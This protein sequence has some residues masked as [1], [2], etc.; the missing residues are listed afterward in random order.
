MLSVRRNP[1]APG[2][3]RT[4]NVQKIGLLA[5]GTLVGITVLA[6]GDLV[7][8][9]SGIC[10]PSYTYG[11]SDVGAIDPV[12]TGVPYT[13][14]TPHWRFA[15]SDTGS[16]RVNE[17]GFRTDRSIAEIKSA[18]MSLPIAVTGDS[19]T[20]LPYG[21]GYDHPFVLERELRQA[22]IRGAEVFGLGR[23]TYS[24]LQAYLFVKKVSADLNPRVI[25]LNLYSGN[26][27]FDLMR[28]D[29]RP[30]FEPKGDGTY[31]IHPPVWYR[32]SDPTLRGSWTEQSRLLYLVRSFGR[33]TGIADAIH[34]FS[35]LVDLAHANGYGFSHALAYLFALNASKG[36]NLV[37]P[38]AYPSQILN[39]YLFF[40]YFPRTKA[41]SLRR[42]EYLLGMIRRQNPGVSL[43]LSPIPSAAL[44]GSLDSDSSFQGKLREMGISSEDVIEQESALLDSSRAIAKRQEWRF[45]DNVSALQK[46]EP[47]SALY[48]SEDLH[49]SPNGSLVVGS[50]EAQALLVIFGTGSP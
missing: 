25:I 37:F 49:L 36:E 12:G 3:L 6:A 15:R 38:R 4:S 27:F 44:A 47:R 19:H 21:H 50:N 1:V 30:Y 35:Y 41:E 11:D 31:A 33:E 46:A 22:G 5:L 10:A 39:Q 18:P 45:I 14:Q 9:L 23:G 40:Q 17:R 32:L 48:L 26:D 24:P 7:C 13:Y 43:I 20:D 34:R 29:D 42:L 8:A 28:I 2:K 16:I